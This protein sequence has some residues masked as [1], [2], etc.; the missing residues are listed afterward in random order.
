METL[1]L[2][3]HEARAKLLA[4]SSHSHDSKVRL[5]LLMEMIFRTAA[6]IIIMI[7]INHKCTHDM[8]SPCFF[9]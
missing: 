3:K 7:I 1:E 8:V 9:F 6:I 5:A 4:K 2:N